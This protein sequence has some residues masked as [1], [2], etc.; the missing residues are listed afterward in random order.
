VLQKSTAF[1]T[2]HFMKPWITRLLP[3]TGITVGRCAWAFPLT[4][5]PD[6]ARFLLDRPS[7]I[8]VGPDDDAAPMLPTHTIDVLA[9]LPLAL[10]I[11][12]PEFIRHLP[13]IIETKLATL[14]RDYADVVI[15][16]VQEPA[17]IK[18]GSAIQ[19]LTR[20]RDRG[21]LRSIGLSAATALDAEWL[22]GTSS[23]KILSVPFDIDEQMIRYRALAAMSEFSMDAISEHPVA[24]VPSAD[25]TNSNAVGSDGKNFAVRFA[26]AMSSLVLPIL[27]TPIG[28]EVDPLSAE[29][30]EAVWQKYALG[31]PAPPPLP[32]SRPPE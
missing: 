32:R 16:H 30:A 2:E 26:L 3:H 17:D 8:V 18:S 20:L 1:K 10:H 15:L 7:L 5:D 29:E 11:H 28:D 22:A 23:A 31:H 24:C 12:E 14:G 27:A 6:N 21:K 19:A 4:L 9:R 13:A 25:A